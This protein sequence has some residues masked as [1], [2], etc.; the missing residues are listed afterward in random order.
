MKNAKGKVP[1]EKVSIKVKYHIK[2]P[3]DIYAQDRVGERRKF[4]PLIFQ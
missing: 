2:R 3:D 4:S 1:Y